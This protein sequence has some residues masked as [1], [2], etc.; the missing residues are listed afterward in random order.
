[1][2]VETKIKGKLVW[3]L[4]YCP[5]VSYQCLVKVTETSVGISIGGNLIQGIVT[6]VSE[7]LEWPEEKS[8]LP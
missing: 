1:M 5:S 3:F 6:K 7:G 2:S 8:Q 4:K